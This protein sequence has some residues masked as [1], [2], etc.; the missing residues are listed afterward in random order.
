M[1]LTNFFVVPAPGHY[2]DR[3][4]VYSGHVTIEAARKAAKKTTGVVVRIGAKVRGD[5]WLRIYEDTCPVV[6]EES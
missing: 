2:G 6:I 1:I 5:L 4:R 3:A